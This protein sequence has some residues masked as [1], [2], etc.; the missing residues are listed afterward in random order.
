MEEELK[1]MLDWA[2]EN[3]DDWKI[4]M[5]VASVG[6][7]RNKKI[8]ASLMESKLHVLSNMISLRIYY[9]LLEDV[10]G[11]VDIV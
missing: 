11:D 6:I 10:R 7:E 5:G 9:M 4:V 2:S 8:K 1:K 3:E